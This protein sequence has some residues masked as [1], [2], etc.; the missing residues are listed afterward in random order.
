MQVQVQPVTRLQ[1]FQTACTNEQSYKP[2]I[3]L[4]VQQE[5]GANDGDTDSDD[6]QNEKHQ[7]HKAIDIVD[8]IRPE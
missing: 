4:S 6:N 5:V 8:L 3:V 7:Q 2:S 1:C